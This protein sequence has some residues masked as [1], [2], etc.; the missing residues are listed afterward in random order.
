MYKNRTGKRQNWVIMSD[1]ATP[2][3]STNIPMRTAN[4]AKKQFPIRELI[5][6][7]VARCL[8]VNSFCNTA[9]TISFNKL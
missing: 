2:N 9:N 7:I 6:A 4:I 8:S 3:L 1:V 5:E